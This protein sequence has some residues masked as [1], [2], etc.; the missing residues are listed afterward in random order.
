MI[1]C[2]NIDMSVSQNVAN[3]VLCVWQL[4]SVLPVQSVDESDNKHGA[5]QQLHL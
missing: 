4:P 5:C 2:A 3:S 1:V